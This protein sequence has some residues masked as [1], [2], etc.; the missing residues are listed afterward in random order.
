[1]SIMDVHRKIVVR[2][3]IIF[4]C[5]VMAVFA[6][7]GDVVQREVRDMS[8]KKPAENVIGEIKQNQKTGL[9]RS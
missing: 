4:I 5:S 6:Y 3:V 1:M 9:D 8:T 2:V 7:A